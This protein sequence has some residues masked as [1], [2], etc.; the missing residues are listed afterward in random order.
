MHDVVA[1]YRCV[2]T[3]LAC[4]SALSL[5]PSDSLVCVLIY[6]YHELPPMDAVYLDAPRSYGVSSSR[7]RSMRPRCQFHASQSG[8]YQMDHVEK[9][10]GIKRMLIAIGFVMISSMH[11]N[12]VLCGA[13]QGSPHPPDNLG[14]CTGRLSNYGKQPETKRSRWRRLVECRRQFMSWRTTYRQTE[15]RM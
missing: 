12:Q 4:L 9:L 6:Q 2:V 10:I 13:V 5:G 11:S 3:Y 15:S 14:Q 8:E 1:L 7:E